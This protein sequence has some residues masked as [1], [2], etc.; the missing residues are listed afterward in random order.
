MSPGIWQPASAHAVGGNDV[1][2][3]A[4]AAGAAAVD[5]AVAA[6]DAGAVD[7]AIATSKVRFVGGSKYADPSPICPAIRLQDASDVASVAAGGGASGDGGAAT[8]STGTASGECAA[9]GGVG[10][11]AATC[12]TGTV[13][14]REGES[15]R[16]HLCIGLGGGDAGLGDAAKC[17]TGTWICTLGES[18]LRPAPAEAT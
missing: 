15:G 12:S 14:T 18:C 10:G 4:A 16:P 9:G 5:I 7:I 13:I 11:V 2:V 8:I 17:S 6:A 1:D 3:A